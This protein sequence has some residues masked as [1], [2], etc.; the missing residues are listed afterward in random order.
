MIRRLLILKI[1]FHDSADHFTGKVVVTPSMNSN[2]NHWGTWVVSFLMQ[3]LLGIMLLL[4]LEI[5]DLSMS[6]KHIFYLWF[7]QRKNLFQ[8]R[9][10]SSSLRYHKNRHNFI[11]TPSDICLCNQDIEDTNHFL[12]LC[13]FFATVRATLAINVIAILQ[14]Y[15]L[16]RLGNKSHL[17]LYGHHAINFADNRKMLLSTIEY[18]RKTRRFLT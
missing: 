17:Y 7:V 11:D 18:I 1:N 9:V 3:L 10:S 16:T 5:F 4:I 14:K 12:F 13:P 2:V 8:L 15:N 6:L